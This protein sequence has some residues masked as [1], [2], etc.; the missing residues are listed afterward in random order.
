MTCEI[1][2]LSDR[3]ETATHK[4]INCGLDICDNE[5]NHLEDHRRID[6]DSKDPAAAGRRVAKANNE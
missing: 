4:C 1:C 6:L 3:I 5:A 2:I